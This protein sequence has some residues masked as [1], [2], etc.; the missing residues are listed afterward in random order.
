MQMF[1][2]TNHDDVLFRIVV[3]HEHELPTMHTVFNL[4]RDKPAKFVNAEVN[5]TDIIDVVYVITTIN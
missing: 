2:E 5:I 1:V 3:N 4:E